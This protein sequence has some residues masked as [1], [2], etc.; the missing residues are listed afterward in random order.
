MAGLTTIDAG[1][2]AAKKA[3]S[4]SG[5]AEL[6]WPAEEAF[7]ITNGDISIIQGSYV[8]TTTTDSSV[9]L[10]AST[11]AAH[12]PPEFDTW[13]QVQRRVRRS[14]PTPSLFRQKHQAP[15]PHKVPHDSRFA[16][17]HSIE[18]LEFTTALAPAPEAPPLPAP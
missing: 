16:A 3:D 10:P 4:G 18:P 7:E 5:T 17:M 11:S 12:S 8:D 13:M 14:P 9:S 1:R 15:G 2:H 6:V